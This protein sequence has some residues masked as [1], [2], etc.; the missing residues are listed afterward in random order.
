MAAYGREHY[1][2]N[3]GAYVARNAR[4]GTATPETARRFP[5]RL[6]ESGPAAGALSA[7][8]L[9]ALMNRPNL[10]SLDMGGTTAKAC[11]IERG[12]PM[13]ASELEVGHLQ[14]FKK[15]SGLPIKISSVD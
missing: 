11:P 4:N 6:M 3:H 9:G 12:R 14:R 8:H 2:R 5:V 15:G 13:I 1:R 10:L 7:A